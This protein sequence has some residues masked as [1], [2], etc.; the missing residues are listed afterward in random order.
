MIWVGIGGIVAKNVAVNDRVVVATA[1][2]A[3]TV[4]V[5]PVRIERTRDY[6]DS[7]HAAVQQASGL[8]KASNDLD[9]VSVVGPLAVSGRIAGLYDGWNATAAT[10]LIIGRDDVIVRVSINGTP[11]G[12]TSAAEAIDAR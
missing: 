8:A 11:V 2:I 7:G 9:V 3:L 4:L 5:V 12:P 10:Q 1:V 6:V